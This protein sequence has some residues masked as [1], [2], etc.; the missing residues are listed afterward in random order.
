[1]TIEIFNNEGEN[2]P[3]SGVVAVIDENTRLNITCSDQGIAQIDAS[4]NVTYFWRRAEMVNIKLL[5]PNDDNIVM[6]VPKD[7]IIQVGQEV[8]EAVEVLL[9]IRKAEIEGAIETP[10]EPYEDVI[11]D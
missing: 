1:M 6:P 4:G 10:I 7:V 3:E 5:F 9:Q 8:S 2:V 11:P